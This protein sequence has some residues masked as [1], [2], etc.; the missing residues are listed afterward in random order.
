MASGGVG[1][2]DRGSRPPRLLMATSVPSTLVAFLL[3]YAE[4]YRKKGWRVEAVSN[5]VTQVEEC[6]NAFDAVHEIGWTRKPTDLVNVTTA[7]ARLRELAV[8]GEFDLVHAHDPIAA[9]VTRFALRRVRKRSHLRVV[10]TAHGFHFYKGAPFPRALIFKVLETVASN[11]TDR[12]IVINKE[13]LAA[14]QSF[15]LSK[16]GGVVYMPGIGVDTS[17]YN[18]ERVAAADVEGVR[19]ELGLSAEQPLFTMLAEFNPDKR[20]RDAV[21]ALAR[22]D[23]PGAVLALAGVGPLMDDVKRQAAELGVADRVKVLGF[24]KDVPALIAASVAV[25]LPSAREGLPRSLMEAACM[26]RPII[27]ADVRGIRELVSDRTGFL[28]EVG[29]VEAIAR[30]MESVATDPALARELGRAGKQAMEPFD[31]RQVLPLHD[32]LYGSLL[33]E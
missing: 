13:D 31:L 11:W 3:P 18:L 32:E 33:S 27:A 21:A 26:E 8:D 23:V 19:R 12:L 1:N 17:R 15:P 25:L 24:R 20:H 28:H 14:A 29:D 5:G 22:S 9:F 4:Y 6:V 16:R 2:P 10:Y 7:A 30:A